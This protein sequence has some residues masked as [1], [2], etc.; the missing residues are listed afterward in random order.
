MATPIPWRGV[1]L[2]T[3]E[4]GEDP[5]APRR[6]V[7]LPASWDDDAA[8]GFVGLLGPATRRSWEAVRLPDEAERW[9][10]PLAAA[11]PELELEAA[12]HWLLLLRQACPDEWAWREAGGGTPSFLLHL[13]AFAD[14]AGG[15]D[16]AA[17]EDAARTAAT[18]LSIARA[19]TGSAT[20][21]LRVAGLD[22]MLASLGLAYDS[23]AGRDIAA[24]ALRRI[25]QAI[26]AR[27]AS[28]ELG[29][30]EGGAADALLGVETAGIAA[31]FSPVTQDFSLTAA[32]E[33]RLAARG[34]TPERA[35]AL[36]LGG[37]TPLRAPTPKAAK[38]MAA[39]LG[40]LIDRVPA[41]GL[42]DVPA[43]GAPPFGRRL[44]ARASGFTQKVT[45]AGQ[46]ILVR[47]AEFEDGTLGEISISGGGGRALMEAVST[48]ISVGLQHGIPLDTFVV[49]LGHV[50]F[51]AQGAVEGDPSIASA[52]S[53]LDYALR[54]LADAYGG[55]R[56]PDPDPAPTDDATEATPLLPLALPVSAGA[57]GPAARRRHLRLV[58]GS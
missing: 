6:R 14:P 3:F 2:R 12:L 43:D 37:E 56:I 16:L 58:G 29:V 24:D 23:E 15:L 19:H 32:S 40:P 33:A 26:E 39:A 46:K 47:T 42:P 57:P 41:H 8:R 30:T 45:I 34:L 18:A 5:D 10:G 22:G 51:G 52:S 31:P 44:P 35:L 27:G 49:A 28:L 48:A 20:A 13:A 7:A 17:L 11:A 38:A 9:I 4:A 36:T 53:P 25:R 21:L 50:R 55:R 1:R 54:A